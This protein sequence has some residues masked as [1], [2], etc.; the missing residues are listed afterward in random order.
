MR[1]SEYSPLMKVF[2]IVLLSLASLAIVLGILLPV[3]ISQILARRVIGANTRHFL[4]R[5]GFL[6]PVM[7]NPLTSFLAGQLMLLILVWGM[8]KLSR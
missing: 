6:Y 5:P 1:L 4:V 2:A 3:A 7:S 8:W